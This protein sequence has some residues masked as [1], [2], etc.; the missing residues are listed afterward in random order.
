MFC[1]PFNLWRWA[2]FINTVSLSHE[3]IAPIADINNLY[4]AS[5]LLI[6]Y[7]EDYTVH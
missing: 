1:V 3:L 4:G 7:A 6:S 5:C 2:S